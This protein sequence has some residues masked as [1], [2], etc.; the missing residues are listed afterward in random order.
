MIKTV[1]PALP[2]QLK[3]NKIIKIK[4]HMAISLGLLFSIIVIVSLVW[5]YFINIYE[6]KYV[7]SEEVLIADNN[8]VLNIYVVPVN[9]F[10]NKALFRSAKASFYIEEG[11]HL[12]DILS[13]KM[14]T[15]RLT[16]KSRKSVG[17]VVIVIKSQKSYLPIKLVI[18]IHAK[19]KDNYL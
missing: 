7:S 1:N 13:D 14:E 6:V 17:E 2:I 15:D 10:G 12:I 16:I 3:I 5:A 11:E 18:P 4:K 8:S 19:N 9:S